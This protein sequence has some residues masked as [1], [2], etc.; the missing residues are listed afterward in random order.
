MIWKQKDPIFFKTMS[1]L[2]IFPSI[3]ALSILLTC[4]I[5][6]LF[7]IYPLIWFGLFERHFRQFLHS[8]ILDVIGRPQAVW[9]FTVKA[10]SLKLTRY[11][12]KEEIKLDIH[13][14]DLLGISF[15]L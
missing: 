10:D 2:W 8:L 15:A 3:G 4:L 9:E 7:I 11:R 14:R 13:G 12:G 6:P 1:L 5:F